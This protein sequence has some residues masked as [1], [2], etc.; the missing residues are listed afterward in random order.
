MRN[1]APLA[2]LALVLPFS[3]EEVSAQAPQPPV[4][5]V[6]TQSIYIDVTLERP[7]TGAPRLAASDFHLFDNGAPQAF[8]LVP[9]ADLPVRAILV[10]DTSRSMQGAKLDQ[11]SR[12]AL[13]FVSRLGPKDEASLL[14]FAAGFEWS[15][16]PQP[17]L[18]RVQA[19]LKQIHAEG[20]T[21]LYDALYAALVLPGAG[22]RSLM[23]LF[24]DGDDTSSWLTDAK[25]RTVAERSN[26]LIHAVALPDRGLDFVAGPSLGARTGF[27]SIAVAGGP[28]VA[29]EGESAPYLRTLREVAESTGGSLVTV[30]SAQQ[31]GRAF[32]SILD[33]VRARYVLRY[34]PVTTPAPGWHKLEV[35]LASGRKERLRVRSGYWVR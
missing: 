28:T 22:S 3:R 30:R 11:L 25:I 4:F 8:E 23:V 31:I 9:A 5:A 7:S 15:G 18:A 26:A 13:D 35:R 29:V 17:D 24:S 16:A 32:N 20:A 12:A 34:D 6:S 1:L 14:T 2:A 21:S 10:F 33:E 19:T 27:G